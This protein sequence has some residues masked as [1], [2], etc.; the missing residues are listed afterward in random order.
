M[1]RVGNASA[2]VNSINLVDADS[3]REAGI[4]KGNHKCFKIVNKT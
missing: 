2:G 1:K 3:A 4:H